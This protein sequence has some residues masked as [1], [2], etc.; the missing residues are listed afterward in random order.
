MKKKILTVTLILSFVSILQVDFRILAQK[1]Q[2]I[3]ALFA[4]GLI[5]TEADEYG[6]VF[7]PNGRSLYFTRRIDRE[8]REQIMTSEFEN[9][10]W[11]MPVVAE[12]SGKY[13]DKEPFISPDGKKIFFASTRPHTDKNNEKNFDIFVSEKNGRGWNEPKNLG[14]MVNSDAYDN[15]PSVAGDGT[16][17]FASRRAGGEGGLDIYRARFVNGNYEKAENLGKA[18]NSAATDADPFIAPDQSYL[19]FCSSRQ[20]GFGSGDLYISFN[21]QGK[22]T[23]PQN[24]GETINHQDFDYTPFVSPDQKMFYFSRGWGEIFQIETSVLN[25]PLLKQKAREKLINK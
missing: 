25:F 16:I 12:F 17:Y 11:T 20:G 24:L 2:K 10:K 3:P 1:Q 13:Y 9:G 6:L 19:I 4:D 15:Y 23:E 21:I 14:L 5:N 18:I 8:G 22:W 7:A